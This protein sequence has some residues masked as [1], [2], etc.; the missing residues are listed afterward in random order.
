MIT[1]MA[2]RSK[3]LLVINYGT[4]SPYD[5]LGFDHNAISVRE[6]ISGPHRH[7]SNACHGLI[8]CS[9]NNSTGLLRQLLKTGQIN[10]QRFLRRPRL[11]VQKPPARTEYSE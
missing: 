5:T 10:Q 3:G 6:V 7:I 2:H 9:H 11:S 4:K 8:Y 1:D